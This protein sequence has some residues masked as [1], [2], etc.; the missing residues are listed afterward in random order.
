MALDRK[1]HRSLLAF[2]RIVVD[3][4]TDGKLNLRSVL[5]EGCIKYSM[6]RRVKLNLENVTNASLFPGQVVAVYGVNPSGY[7]FVAQKIVDTALPAMPSTP[8]VESDG[9]IDMVLGTPPG[10]HVVPCTKILTH[11]VTYVGCCSWPL[12]NY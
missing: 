1:G 5:L 6:G 9:D 11:H 12:H 7:C 8:I 10:L 4:E 3:G 2:N